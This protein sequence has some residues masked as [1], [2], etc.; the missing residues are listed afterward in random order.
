MIKLLLEKSQFF[1]KDTIK[2]I[3]KAETLIEKKVSNPK[4]YI[5]SDNFT[6]LREYF[7]R[8]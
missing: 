1:V 3:K 6:N 7:S 2:Y 4:Y 8:K 5:W